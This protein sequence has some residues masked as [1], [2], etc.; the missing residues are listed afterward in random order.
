MHVLPRLLVLAL[1]VSTP[2][3]LLAAKLKVTTQFDKTFDF[4]GLRTFAWHPS[5]TGDVKL[6]QATNDNPAQIRTLVEP[7]IVRDV[8]RALTG[9][10]F[11]RAT[12]GKPDLYVYYY[13]LIGPNITAQTMGQFIAPVP[14]WGLPPFAPATSS[15]EIYEQGALIVDLSSPAHESMVWRGAATAEIDSEATPAAREK[16]IDDAVKEM[17]KKFPPKK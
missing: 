10:G 14:A 13:V 12:G 6:L 5:G 11:A 17:F 3:A 15:L 1:A 4:K 16:R 2:A 9:S 8:E 7:V